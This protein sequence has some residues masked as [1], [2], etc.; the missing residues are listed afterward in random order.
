MITTLLQCLWLALQSLNVPVI[1]KIGNLRI[2]AT[3]KSLL[4]SSKKEMVGFSGSKDQ[5]GTFFALTS[6]LL[7]YFHPL[8]I[9]FSII[10]VFISKSSFA[11][12]SMILSSMIYLFFISKRLFAVF[13]I[14]SSIIS[15]LFFLKV[16]KLKPADFITRFNVWRYAIKSTIKGEIDI[17]R[18]GRSYIITTNPIF[19]YGFGRFLTIF[20]FVPQKDRV[21]NFINEKFTHAHN[22][23]VEYYF[24]LGYMGLISMILLVGY[25]VY[26][27]VIANKSKEVVLY[28]TS[29]ISYLLNASGN[30]ISQI[31]VSGMFLVLFYGMFKGVLRETK[32]I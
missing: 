10:G 3:F 31:T 20:P 25:F 8:L 7:L 6:P 26:Q 5:L 1:I 9:F 32:T 12:V 22:D 4:D 19:G 16:D 23:P 11:F 15:I 28:F 27:F 14:V 2:D 21:F 30:F 29:I 17:E 24:E 18:D 13:L